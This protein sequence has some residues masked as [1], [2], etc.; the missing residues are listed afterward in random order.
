MKPLHLLKIVCF[1]LGVYSCEAW[2]SHTA[3]HSRRVETAT[4]SLSL[5][6]ETA[7][8]LEIV[9][10]TGD[11][12]SIVEAANFMVDA[13]WLGSPRQ[14]VP[15][16]DEIIAV[17][18][19]I[20]DRLVEEQDLD[21]TAKYGERMGKRLLESQFLAARDSVSGKILGVVGME[22]SLLDR[23]KED[24][25]TAEESESMLKN[26]VSSL[27]PKQRRQYKDS[28]ANQLAEE[29]LS[30]DTEAVCCLSNL[31]VSPDARR[32]GVAVKLCQEVER[33]A[34]EW[35]YDS[36]FLKVETENEAARRL[37]EDKMKYSLEYKIDAAKATRVNV[38][39]G[40]FDDFEAETLILTKKV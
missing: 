13:F 31:A 36:V 10:S 15:V 27:G 7:S 5:A 39:T 28:S 3:K 11:E 8:D 34:K 14:L 35:G 16:Q 4:L 32:R 6:Q 24:I 20:R 40:S 23:S 33:I 22:V 30:P 38:D 18:D 21:L 9:A 26:A 29:L 37:Y 12:K 25:L 17:S 19:S 2:V 1:I